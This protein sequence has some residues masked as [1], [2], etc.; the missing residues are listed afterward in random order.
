MK[1][2]LDLQVKITEKFHFLF[3]SLQRFSENQFCF[4]VVMSNWKVRKSKRVTLKD[5][6]RSGQKCSVFFLSDPSVKE[7]GQQ[8]RFSPVALR[9]SEEILPGEEAETPR[10]GSEKF[11]QK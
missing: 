9:R 2:C 4:S 7:K 11:P 8:G 6:R 1:V 5:S 10:S 3:R